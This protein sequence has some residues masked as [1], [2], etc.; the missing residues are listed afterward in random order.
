MLIGTA[1]KLAI[2]LTASL[3]VN[4]FPEQMI[5]RCYKLASETNKDELW[6]KIRALSFDPDRFEF[7]SNNSLILGRIGTETLV[8][9]A[10]NAFDEVV[11][12]AAADQWD[13]EWDPIQK[14]APWNE[15]E[16]ALQDVSE[17]NR[18]L[19]RIGVCPNETVSMVN[20]V[21]ASGLA[22]CGLASSGVVIS[23]GDAS[24][25][26]DKLTRLIQ[27][28]PLHSQTT[29][30]D[31]APIALKT[32]LQNTDITIGNARLREKARQLFDPSGIFSNPLI[33]TV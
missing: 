16:S 9:S 14:P 11:G 32:I 18:I 7:T 23:W 25:C 24:S 29:I 17:E 26:R 19:L 12:D 21:A 20:S 5:A 1:G 4:P 33:E 28:A 3:K 30:C 2:P 31:L 22:A 10:L 15:I 8:S 27:D 6:Q 13:Q